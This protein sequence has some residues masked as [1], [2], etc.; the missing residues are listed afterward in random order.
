MADDDM[1]PQM[2]GVVLFIVLVVLVFF[3]LLQNA[4]GFMGDSFCSLSVQTRSIFNNL[5]AGAWGRAIIPD[6]IFNILP[7]MCRYNVEVETSDFE[8]LLAEKIVECFNKYGAGRMDGVFPH[9]SILCD[10]LIY[11]AP[12]L[13]YEQGADNTEYL[14][15][16][17]DLM[18][19][20]ALILND[21]NF[22]KTFDY[23]NPGLDNSNYFRLCFKPVYAQS[24]Y[25]AIFEG[26]EGVRGGEAEECFGAINETGVIPNPY[27]PSISSYYAVPPYAAVPLTEE[28]E[29]L[30]FYTTSCI[31]PSVVPDIYG[32]FD[33]AS[34]GENGCFSMREA[35]LNAWQFR[36]TRYVQDVF[37][38]TNQD[39]IMF[40]NDLC[41]RNCEVISDYYSEFNT[42]LSQCNTQCAALANNPYYTSPSGDTYRSREIPSFTIAGENFNFQEETRYFFTGVSQ[43]G[44]SSNYEYYSLLKRGTFYI[45]FFDY[46]DWLQQATDSTWHSFPECEN[47][48]IYLGGTIQQG[49][50]F[51][52]TSNN[53]D[54][55]AVCFVPYVPYELIHLD[56]FESI[57]Q[58]IVV[59]T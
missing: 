48:I 19:V 10:A 57:D 9:A 51:W 37:A 59:V 14:T 40:C 3:P 45:R 5:F 46:A 41:A 26:Y 55:V 32:S 20:Y 2:I 27:T 13:T 28:G 31:P 44:E 49:N 4:T 11:D 29:A 53:H 34:H 39:L 47:N 52:D 16:G 38:D 6:D 18:R 15:T 50:V 22:E 24:I 58:G 30:Y 36:L 7:L 17:V 21:S 8:E 23:D 56:E 42:C 43:V 33:M 35:I 12:V 54:Y 1:V 25:K